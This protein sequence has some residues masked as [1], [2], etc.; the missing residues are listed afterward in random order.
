MTSGP[1]FDDE[2]QDQSFDALTGLVQMRTGLGW[3][4]QGRA[5]LRRAVEARIK[6]LALGG[7][8]A[9][10][11]VV[12]ENQAEWTKLIPYLV[13][14]RTA[15][16]GNPAQFEALSLGLVPDLTLRREERRLVLVSA[17]CS[18][19]EEAY[20]LAMVA[21][22]SGLLH[23]NWRVDI[24]ALDINQEALKTAQA[25]LYPASAL[26]RLAPS[27]IQ[28]WFRRSGGRF[29]V[30]DELKEMISWGVFN[31]AGE[32]PWPWPDLKGQVDVLL[33]RSVLLGLSP[34][35]GKKAT[36]LL[37]ELLGPGGVVLMSPVE[38]LPYAAKQF[39]AERWGG[40]MY[41]RR[42]A[43]KFKANPGHP[44]RKA[45]KGLDLASKDQDRPSEPWPLPKGI[46][47]ELKKSSRFL[48][49]GRPDQAWPHLEAVLDQT[50]QKGE[51]C[52][53]ALGLAVRG[54]LICGRW[55]EARDLAERIISLTEDRSWAHLLLSEAWAGED[56]LVRARTEWGQAAEIMTRTPNWKNDP[57][58]RL[59]PVYSQVDPAELVKK[60]LAAQS[61]E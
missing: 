2:L 1:I 28:R 41:W 57:Y 22:E 35:A 26:S 27:R 8:S 50:A 59:D 53:E 51:L 46:T 56:R 12:R 21:R 4:P 61:A 20:S 36:A 42:T 45:Q 37:A 9:Y 33:I 48:A 5:A 44:S 7:V 13:D 34:L 14:G 11:G 32:D 52:P 10:L 19:G 58:W 39:E 6:A 25:G 15:F 30:R 54:H 55:A 40:V 29:M 43:E 24:F 31:L 23:K 49:Q 38:G 16:F 18:T 47:A 3:G 17:G 60:R